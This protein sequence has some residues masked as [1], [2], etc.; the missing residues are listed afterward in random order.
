[1][2]VFDNNLLNRQLASNYSDFKLNLRNEEEEVEWQIHNFFVTSPYL[3]TEFLSATFLDF[4]V[5]TRV[6]KMSQEPNQTWKYSHEDTFYPFY[7]HV[8]SMYESL[9]TSSLK[10][11]LHM[12]HHIFHFPQQCTVYQLWGTFTSIYIIV[13][14]HLSSSGILEKMLLGKFELQICAICDWLGQ[15]VLWTICLKV[16]F[17]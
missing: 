11:I 16:Q 12:C 2:K 9:T 10:N 14:H 1:M 4:H 13:R 8:T 7:P 15:A 3:V 6:V 5:R 17:S